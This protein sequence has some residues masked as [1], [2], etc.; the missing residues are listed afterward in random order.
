VNV[1]DGRLAGSGTITNAVNITSAGG[2]LAPGETTPGI[3]QINAN[4]TLAAGAGFEVNLGGGV[5]NPIPGTTYD[6]V[7]IGNGIGA[8]S[9]GTVNINGSELLI[10]L[11][12]GI[13]MNNLFFLV[14]NDGTD[15]V[16]GTFFDLAQG[17]EFTVNGQG[18]RISYNA[19]TAD[20]TTG[21]FLDAGNDIAVMAVPEPGSV[22]LMLGGL[23]LIAG[24]RR[25]RAR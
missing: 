21:T 15:A 16:N 4:L 3:L 12:T 14:M 6:Q 22:L 13:Q 18:W 19:N 11:S 5:G 10:T 17:E 2:A 23:G 24:T 7:R 9:T 25:R 1:S 8:V 20:G